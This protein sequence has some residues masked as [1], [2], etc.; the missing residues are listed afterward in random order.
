MWSF[1]VL[2]EGTGS[3]HQTQGQPIRSSLPGI[4]H[5]NERMLVSVGWSLKPRTY[6]SRAVYCIIG[7]RSTEH[8][9][10][11]RRKQMCRETDEGPEVRDWRRG[12]EEK[13]RQHWS[14]VADWPLLVF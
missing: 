3:R 14:K 1:P 5:C 9:T 12:Q 10:A 7:S 11:G 13:K 4:Y 6:N 8:L 2:T